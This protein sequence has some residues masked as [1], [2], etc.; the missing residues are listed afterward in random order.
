MM[1]KKHR[2]I[3]DGQKLKE[4]EFATEIVGT[5]GALASANMYSVGNLTTML[6]Q[7]DQMIAQLQ[8]QLKETKRNISWGIKKGLEQARLNDIQEI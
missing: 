6:E 8:G 1:V 2:V 4:G 3:I 7:K 5:M